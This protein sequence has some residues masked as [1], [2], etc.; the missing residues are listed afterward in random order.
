MATVI[1]SDVLDQASALTQEEQ[2]MLIDILR[3][4]RAMT[5]RKSLAAYARKVRR[6]VAAGRL[7]PEPVEKLIQRLRSKPKTAGA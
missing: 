6:D 3:R 5:W 7:K 1:F 2:G 4:R